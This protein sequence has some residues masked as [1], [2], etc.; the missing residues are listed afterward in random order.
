MNRHLEGKTNM[1]DRETRSPQQ[2]AEELREDASPECFGIKE[3]PFVRRLTPADCHELADHMDDLS[4]ALRLLRRMADA[5]FVRWP[6]THALLAKYQEEQ[7]QQPALKLVHGPENGCAQPAP[8]AR[9]AGAAEPVAGVFVLGA[10]QAEREGTELRKRITE[11]YGWKCEL[12]RERDEARADYEETFRQLEAT[13]AEL[14]ALKAQEHIG[15]AYC[16]HMTNATTRPI[17]EFRA[18]TDWVPTGNVPAKLYAAPVP[19]PEPSL[20]TLVAECLR[21]V[22]DAIDGDRAETIRE[23]VL[24]L[25]R[26]VDGFIPLAQHE[27]IVAA[28]KTQAVATDEMLEQAR[29]EERER[30]YAAIRALGGEEE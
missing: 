19:P 14:A 26:C 5:T 9:P 24:R 22:D 18:P 28:L 11:A 3:S 10:E 15:I 8:L 2:W 20:L 29:A 7:D 17:F 21:K 27:A 23:L 4:E 25:K 16:D 13:T 1:R 30:C 12:E 6:D